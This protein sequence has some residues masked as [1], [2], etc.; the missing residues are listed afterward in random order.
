M[1]KKYSIYDKKKIMYNIKKINEKDLYINIYNIIK[2]Q[3]EFTK[4]TNGMFFDFNKLSNEMLE[5]IEDLVYQYKLSET[6]EQTIEFIK[7]STEEF[8]NIDIKGN[9]LNNIEKQFLKFNKK[10]KAKR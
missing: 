9:R 1:N 7:Y 8:N 3:V 6:D 5:M 4:N 2:G 10:N